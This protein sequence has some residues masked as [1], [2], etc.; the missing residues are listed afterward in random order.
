MG[1]KS[2]ISPEQGQ[3]LIAAY[4]RL[5]SKSAA[6]REIGVSEDA[7][8]RYLSSIP[9]AAAPVVA[10]QRQV[11]EA[12]GA[13]LWDTRQALTDNYQ[14][15]LTLV[16]Q[17][18]RGILE[19]RQGSDGPYTTMTPISTH[20]AAL[21][22]V[23]EHIQTGLKLYQL[24]LSIDETRAFQQAVLAAIGEADDATKQRVLAKLEE[25]RALDLAL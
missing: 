25:R 9:A 20:V 18:E 6:A 19:E 21:R 17:L 13:S 1:R 14:R 12:A 16:A 4:Q 7:A 23:R 11:L 5:G 22:E 8:A 2:S 10:Q 3:K 24:L 15:A